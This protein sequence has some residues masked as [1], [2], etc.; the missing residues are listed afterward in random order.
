MNPRLA[1]SLVLLLPTLTAAQTPHARLSDAFPE[2]ARF[3]PRVP[4]RLVVEFDGR[5]QNTDNISASIWQLDRRIGQCAPIPAL[6]DAHRQQLLPCVL[7]ATDFHGYWVDV[8]LKD[9]GGHLLDHRPTAIDIS[10]NW[11]KFP[12]Y[13]YLAHYNV[14]EGTDPKSWI[15]EL[16]RFHINGLEFYD[17]Q[18]RHDQPLAGTIADP[19]KQWKDIAGR[20]VDGGIVRELIDEAHHH[21]MMAMAY[22][23]SYSAYD[24]VFTRKKNPLPLQWATWSTPDGPR[25]AATA[26]R[27][28]IRGDH[29]STGSLFYMNQNDPGWQRYIFG[30]MHHLFAV[31]PFDGWHIDT[32]GEKGGYSFG[33]SHI[34]YVA[35]FPGYIDSASAYLHKSIVFNAVNAVGQVRTAHSAADIVYSELW[36]DHE[37]FASLLDTAEQIHVANPE[38]GVVF[39]AYVHRR[40]TSDPPAPAAR[41]FNPPAVLLTDAAIFASG[42]AHIELGDGDRMLSSE[43]FPADRGLT[44]SAS[45]RTALRHNYDYLTAYENYLRDG[46]TPAAI[47]VRIANHPTDA[48]GLPETIWDIAREKNGISIIHLINLLGSRDPH[49]RDVEMSRPEPTLLQDLRLE[50]VDA[51]GVRS[52]G[53]ASPDV[54]GGKFH[55]LHF[56]KK[57]LNGVAVI[58]LTVPT[59]CYWDTIFLS[60]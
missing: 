51:P 30:Q 21:N 11:K 2:K 55:P 22:N 31:Y 3:A 39:A 5:P 54:D 41:Q 9:A 46:T 1:A 20:T 23:A 29:W 56:A 32:F 4:V 7:P 43:Y 17:F 37:T 6:P 33:G 8:V 18:Y 48:R 19:A 10:S 38:D 59:L 36:D 15:D 35:G 44:L 60:R 28:A 26:K 16:N 53:W 14:D 52:A 40:E 27:L 57:R 42:A 47:K 25:T 50:I 24:D 45:L 49:W 34:D 58:Q 12:R 13:G